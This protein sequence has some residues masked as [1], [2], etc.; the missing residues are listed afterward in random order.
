MSEEPMIANARDNDRLL[1]TVDEAAR[2]LSIGRSHLYEYLLRGSL[3]SVHIGRS[4]RIASSDLQAFIDQ[5][6]QDSPDTSPAAEPPARIRPVKR[7]PKPP[8]RR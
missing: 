7:V 5:L 4:R 8:R 2:R 6:L 1:I 3:R